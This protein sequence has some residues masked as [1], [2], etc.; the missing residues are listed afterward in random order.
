MAPKKAAKKPAKKPAKQAAGALPKKLLKESTTTLSL[1]TIGGARSDVDHLF[2]KYAPFSNGKRP[3]QPFIVLQVADGKMRVT[4]DD[5]PASVLANYPDTSVVLVQWPGKWKSDF[6][7]FTVA[8]AKAQ[9][10][11]D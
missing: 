4:V 5:D 1:D 9:L 7:K 2:S 11:G 6:F 3:H 10:K 8:E